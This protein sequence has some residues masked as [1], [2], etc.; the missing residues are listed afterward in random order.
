MNEYLEELRD[1]DPKAFSKLLTEAKSRRLVDGR[2]LA[3]DKMKAAKIYTQEI[4]RQNAEFNKSVLKSAF[5]ESK[6]EILGQSVKPSKQ[7]VI[8]KLM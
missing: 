2:K 5:S 6:P 8:M 1:D 4:N 3:V 7:E